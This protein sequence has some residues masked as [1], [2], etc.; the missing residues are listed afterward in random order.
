MT[1]LRLGIGI[2]LDDLKHFGTWQCCNDLL[3]ISVN[4]GASCSAQCLSVD[5]DIPSGPE[6]LRQFWCL[7]RLSTSG[8]CIEKLG[9]GREGPYTG[10][11][12]LVKDGGRGSGW[13]EG[14][15]NGRLER[16]G[17]GRQGVVGLGGANGVGR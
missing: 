10:A 17:A 15:G 5:G 7:K 9:G 2:I 12:G 11:G 13:N 1:L 16:G 6:A 14:V 3:K 8:V 4:T